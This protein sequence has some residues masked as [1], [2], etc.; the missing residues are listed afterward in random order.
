MLGAALAGLAGLS[1]VALWPRLSRLR[2]R[3]D[4]AALSPLRLQPGDS[5]DPTLTPRFHAWVHDGAGNGASILPWQLPRPPKPLTTLHLPASQAPAVRHFG[6]RLA[7]YHQLDDRSRLGGLAYRVGVQFRPVLWFVPSKANASNN[8]PWDD[9]WL[10]EVDDARL[11]AL[12]AWQPRRPTLIVL[13]HLPAPRASA[14]LEALTGAAVRTEHAIR[15]IVL[16]ED[17]PA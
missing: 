5:P 15:V 17:L 16:E 13:Q 7:G 14:T 8:T 11:A 1:L 3:Y 4:D 9:A 6:Y 12:R 10:E 2:R